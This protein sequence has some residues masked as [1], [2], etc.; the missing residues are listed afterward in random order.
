MAFIQD[1]SNNSIAVVVQLT[2]K[3]L[4][5]AADIVVKAF[6]SFGNRQSIKMGSRV[7]IRHVE[8]SAE[9]FND[10]AQLQRDFPSFRLTRYRALRSRGMLDTICGHTIVEREGLGDTIIFRYKDVTEYDDAGLVDPSYIH[11]PKHYSFSHM[12]D[13]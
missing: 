11:P 4:E 5:D 3:K 7:R 12:A 13:L 1:L 6:G 9:K 10:L 2:D 8:M